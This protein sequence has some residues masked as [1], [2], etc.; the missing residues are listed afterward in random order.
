MNS[1]IKLKNSIWRSVPNSATDEGTR[2]IHDEDDYDGG[3]S[4]AYELN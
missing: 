2:L 3:D 4:Y 1:D